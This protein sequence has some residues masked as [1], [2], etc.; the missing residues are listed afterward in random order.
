MGWFLACPVFLVGIFTAKSINQTI[1]SNYVC[2]QGDYKVHYLKVKEHLYKAIKGT[3]FLSAHIKLI[4][5]A[6]VAKKT[7]LL[8]GKM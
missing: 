6:E 7:V 1:L 2:R 5:L 3:H 8:G 4:W